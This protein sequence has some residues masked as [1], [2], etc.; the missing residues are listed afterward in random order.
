MLNLV[1]DEGFQS[2]ELNTPLN[3]DDETRGRGPRY[4]QY[5]ESY[6]QVPELA[7]GTYFPSATE[8]RATVRQHSILNGYEIKF[9]INSTSK[10]LVE[11]K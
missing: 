6:V 4:G 5:T 11:C 7:V 1:E 9:I 2:D 8:L 10:V 3:S